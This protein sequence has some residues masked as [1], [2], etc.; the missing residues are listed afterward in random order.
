LDDEDKDIY[1]AKFAWSVTDR[2]SNCASLKADAK[3]WQDVKF[4]FD[5]AKCDRIFDELLN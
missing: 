1:V 3:K 5:V 2:L 4:T